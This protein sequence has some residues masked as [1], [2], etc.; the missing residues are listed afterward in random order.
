MKGGT[1]SAS[2]VL[3]NGTTVG[4]LVALNSVG[5]VVGDEKGRVW[6]APFEFGDEFGGL[7]MPE[8]G[9]PSAEPKLP[10]DGGNTAIAIVATDADLTQAQATRMATAAHDGIARAI[11]P[12]H[13]PNDGDMVFA[14]A[15]GA[16]PLEDP[17]RDPLLLG[18]AA[19]VCLSRAIARAV[20]LARPEPGDIL[21]AW[22]TVYA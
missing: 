7:G 12:S 21:S 14:A 20:Y 8:P 15:T 9:D 11:L 17:V 18:H 10:G 5:S 22:S 2:L 3:D 6:A 19:A 1:G 4:A 16:R 13:T